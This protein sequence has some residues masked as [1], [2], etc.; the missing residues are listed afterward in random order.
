MRKGGPDLAE[1]MELIKQ[2]PAYA[3]LTW[4]LLRDPRVP[5]E[6]KLVL[7]AVGAYV[8]MPLDIIPDFIPVLGQVDDVAV[9]LLGLRWFIR[10]APEEVVS[11]HLAKMARNEDDMRRDLEQAQRLL[12]EGFA[13]VREEFDR[14][15]ARQRGSER[16]GQGG[17]THE[18]P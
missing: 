10:S 12:G 13:K 9:V 6:Q 18:R 4:D 5:A 15:L 2:L 8:L 3:R 11:E 7:A 16:D 1:A 14:I 17:T